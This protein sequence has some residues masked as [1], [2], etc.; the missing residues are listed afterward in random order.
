MIP[1]TLFAKSESGQ[2]LYITESIR[3]IFNDWLEYTPTSGDRVLTIVEHSIR[4]ACPVCSLQLLHAGGF[5]FLLY[6]ILT[7]SIAVSQEW[8]VAYQRYWCPCQDQSSDEASGVCAAHSLKR[9]S[10]QRQAGP[11]SAIP[12]PWTWVLPEGL[13]PAFPIRANPARNASSPVK[14]LSCL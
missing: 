8:L 10:C 6:T 9:N 2:P 14:M 7:S 13:C 12:G 1:V 3:A 5:P 4:K 11:K